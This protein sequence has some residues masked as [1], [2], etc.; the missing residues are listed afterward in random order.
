MS[1]INILDKCFTYNM[2]VEVAP[3]HQQYNEVLLNWK[4]AKAV[5]NVSWRLIL[6]KKIIK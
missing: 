3:Q 4:T 2:H 6:L 5:L 1:R